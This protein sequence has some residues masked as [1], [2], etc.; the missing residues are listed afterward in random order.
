MNNRTSVLQHFK[1]HFSSLHNIQCSQEPEL[2]RLKLDT[3]TDE[4]STTSTLDPTPGS[5]S[6]KDT[7]SPDDLCNYNKLSTNSQSTMELDQDMGFEPVIPKLEG[8]NSKSNDDGIV[9]DKS[10]AVED[11]DA[12]HVTKC[13]GKH[14]TLTNKVS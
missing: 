12:T 9:I 13:V 14:D 2:K 4:M 6:K 7:S 11:G 8:S 10:V 3:K 1:V 5:T